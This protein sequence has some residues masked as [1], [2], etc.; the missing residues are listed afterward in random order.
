M[1][2]NIAES[3]P[4]MVDFASSLRSQEILEA[5]YLSAQRNGEAIRLPLEE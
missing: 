1:L 2:L 5:A 4:S 3:K